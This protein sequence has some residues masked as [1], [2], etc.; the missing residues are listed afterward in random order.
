MA[1]KVFVHIGLPKTATTYLQTILW[2]NRAA[3]EDQGVRL[4]GE[5]RVD[6][7]WA[8][9]VVREEEQFRLVSGPHRLEAWDRVRADVATW[10]GTAVISHEFLAAA[11]A[12]QAARMVEQLAP[13]QVE[14]VVTAREPLGLFTASWQE[15][16][17]N[18]DVR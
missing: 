8:T 6:H 5:G 15:S 13:A 1:D 18:R 14:V 12:E 9:R 16:I 4:P 17:K 3:L 11:T 10:S 2:S 7:L